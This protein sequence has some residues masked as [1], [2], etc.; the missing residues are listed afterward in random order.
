M[1]TLAE[2]KMCYT[3]VLQHSFPKS[4]SLFES[5]DFL[6]EKLLPLNKKLL[7]DGL[8]LLRFLGD[9]TVRVTFFDPQYRGVLDK[10]KYGNEG[11]QRGRE[12]A[13]LPQMSE[14]TILAFLS[15]I[16]R[17]LAPSGYLF[18]WVDKFHL[19]QTVSE[20]IKG[21]TALQIVDMITWDKG[22]IGM[23]YRTRR[24]AEYLVV[25]QKNPIFAKS[26]WS[27][28]D[29]PDV[30]QEKIGARNHTHN[31]PIGLQK[32]LILATTA[33]GDVVLDPAAGGFTVFEA[34]RETKRDFIGGD[35]VFGEEVWTYEQD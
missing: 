32:K 35:I 12:R 19:M 7:T 27:L 33:P 9:H 25:V 31:K 22:V 1:S 29:I 6:N 21:F 14:E 23:G 26:T 16:E 8:K 3:S 4:T 5:R 30:W 28:H 2:R 13:V 18:L 15:E 11:K 24:R 34:C 10:L 17:V 20:W